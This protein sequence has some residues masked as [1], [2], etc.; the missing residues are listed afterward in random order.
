MIEPRHDYEDFFNAF[1]SREWEIGICP[2]V[3]TPF[4]TVKANTK[5]VEYTCVEAAVIAISELVY[6][7]CCFG[8][9]GELAGVGQWLAALER[10][11]DGNNYRFQRSLGAQAKVKPQYSIARLRDQIFDVFEAARA[12]AKQSNDAVWRT[13]RKERCRRVFNSIR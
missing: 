12:E 13:C 8:G 2:L 11:V 6:D 3:K 5:W 10:F 1:A 4:N 7:D 9:C